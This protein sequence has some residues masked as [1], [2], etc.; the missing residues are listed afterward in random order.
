MRFPTLHWIAALVLLVGVAAGSGPLWLPAMGGYLVVVDPLRPADAI[1]VLAGNAPQRLV[2]GETLLRDRYASWLIVSNERLVSHGLDVTWLDLHRAG[3][4]AP[5]LPD[6]ALLVLDPPPESTIDEARR[7]AAMMQQH[8]LRSAILVTDAY[9][10]RRASM[11]FGAEFRRHGLQVIS[12]P[13]ETSDVHLDIWWRDS[14]SALTVVEEYTKL[15][16]YLVQGAY[17]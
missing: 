5:G 6:A 14:T 16:A 1:V 13:T 7:S 11:L 2:R 15:A 12:S 10:S 8:G 3:V 4:S 17:W 9:H